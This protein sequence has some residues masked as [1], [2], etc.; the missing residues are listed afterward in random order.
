MTKLDKLMEL[1]N[2]E[3]QNRRNRSEDN[4]RQQ[5]YYGDYYRRVI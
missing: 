5:D 4:L 1:I 3:K 2:L